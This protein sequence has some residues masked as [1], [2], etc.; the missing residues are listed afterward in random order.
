MRTVKGRR[1][2][3][4]ISRHRR[5]GS[6]RRCRAEPRSR[7]ACRRSELDPAVSGDPRDHDGEHI[8]IDH[9]IGAGR[10]LVLGGPRLEQFERQFAVGQ[11]VDS[12]DIGTPLPEHADSA[13]PLRN[14]R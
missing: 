11:R 13:E 3:A 10:K 7:N 1:D 9:D 5:G 2:E 12:D 8:D 4:E 6:R 14:L